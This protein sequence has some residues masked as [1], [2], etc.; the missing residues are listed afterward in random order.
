M[1]ELQDPAGVYRQCMRL[2]TRL[3]AKGLVHC[4]FN[5]FNLLVRWAG[6]L[7]GAGSPSLRAR[8]ERR[9]APQMDEAE[10]LVL[11]DFPQM[12]STSHADALHLFQRDVDCVN[13]RAPE[14]LPCSPA[15]AR[16]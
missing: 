1:R 9:G 6:S 4:D 15:E 3:A 8:Q 11:I 10:Q 7:L 14:R 13:R 2:M 12:V 16:R 5:E